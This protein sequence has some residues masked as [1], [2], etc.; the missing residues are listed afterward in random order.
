MSRRADDAIQFG[1]Q[2]RIARILP[3]E[4]GGVQELADV[5]AL[6]VLMRHVAPLEAVEHVVLVHLQHP[7]LFIGVDARPQH[8][9]RQTHLARQQGRERVGH[10]G[11]MGQGQSGR[12]L[13][14]L[15]CVRQK[16]KP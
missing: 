7:V 13:L 16:G 5:F 1:F 10:F 6:P 12:V 3:G 4:R 8:A 14:R 15:Y 9:A 2:G 11:G